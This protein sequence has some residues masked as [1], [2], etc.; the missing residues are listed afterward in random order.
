MRFGDIANVLDSTQN[1]K[2]YN[3]YNG[4]P[5]ITLSILR[6]PGS[7]TVAVVD[8]VMAALPELKAQL[9]I[10]INLEIINDRSQSIRASIHDVQMTMLFSALLVVG[11]IFL[12]LRTMTATLIPSVA[13]P[14]AIIGTF[15]GMAAWATA[16]TICR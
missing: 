9:P 11:V 10:S 1:I 4:E 15:A 2:N 6:Q 16:S 14:I 3:M 8:E 5:T 12:F 7:N 13:L